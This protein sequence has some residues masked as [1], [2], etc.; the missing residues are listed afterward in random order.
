MNSR[1]GPYWNF[2]FSKIMAQGPPEK[3]KIKGN[4]KTKILAPPLGL[5]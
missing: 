4:Y 1:G 5:I 2:S 3:K